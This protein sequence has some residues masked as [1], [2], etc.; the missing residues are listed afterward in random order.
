MKPEIHP[1][2]HT[3]K[4]VMTDGTEYFTRSTYGAEG[5][6]L[7]LDIDSKSHPAWTGGTQQIL[8]RGGRVSR[9]QKKFSGFLKK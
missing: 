3:I 9:F 2:Y 6:T 5:D 4:V 8:D 1:D 7:N